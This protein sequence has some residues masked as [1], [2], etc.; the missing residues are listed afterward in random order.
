MVGKRVDKRRPGPLGLRLVGEGAELD[1]AA[2]R[3]GRRRWLGLAAAAGF[4]GGSAC[5]AEAAGAGFATGV[6][7]NLLRSSWASLSSPALVS[8]AVS[9]SPATSSPPGSAGLTL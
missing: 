8:N 2:G 5:G 1:D 3:S 7:G 6:S 4:V 9:L